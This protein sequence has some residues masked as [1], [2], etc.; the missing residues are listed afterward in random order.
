MTMAQDDPQGMLFPALISK[1]PAVKDL[2][3]SHVAYYRELLPHL[4]MGEV[5]EWLVGEWLSSN[6]ALVL[7]AVV[8]VER[9]YPSLS[10]DERNVVDVSFVENLPVPGRPGSDIAEMFGPTLAKV[11]RALNPSF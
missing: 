7:D 9:I 5:T 10:A 2:Y 6:R 4:L 1:A 3:R 11:Y 8:E